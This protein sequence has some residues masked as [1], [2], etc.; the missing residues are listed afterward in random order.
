M[1]YQ[2]TLR[3]I[4]CQGTLRYFYKISPFLLFSRLADKVRGQLGIIGFCG[5]KLEDYDSEDVFGMKI[6][7]MMH[8]IIRSLF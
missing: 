6:E 5:L 8:L 1:K 2:N 7:E 4:K 3:K